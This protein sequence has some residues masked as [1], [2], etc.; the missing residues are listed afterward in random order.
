[1]SDWSDYD[2]KPSGGMW[3]KAVVG[4]LIASI[5]LDS[6][7]FLGFYDGFGQG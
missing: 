1:M 4:N 7:M 3:A 2:G 5:T 6:S